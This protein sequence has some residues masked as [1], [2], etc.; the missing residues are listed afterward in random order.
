MA[1]AVVAG[2]VFISEAAVEELLVKIGAWMPTA[3]KIFVC[4]R[5]SWVYS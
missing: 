2:G 1:A 3:N 4:V 5:A